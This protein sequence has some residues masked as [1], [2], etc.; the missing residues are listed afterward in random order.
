MGTSLSMDSA[1]A[2]IETR[3]RR[4]I[5]LAVVVWLLAVEPVRLAL[6]L[7]GALPRLSTFGAVDW[8]VV[9]ARV[10]LVAA[11]VAVGRRLRAPSREAWR[12]VAIW[13]AASIA[14]SMLSQ[15]WPA[16][17]TGRAPSEARIATALAVVR[18][19][20]LALAAVTLARRGRG[21]RAST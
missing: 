21:P 3:A 12:A 14:V 6:A 9:A 11:A 7:D 17:P 4:A 1:A 8:L 2:P 20:L 10:A 16:L 5:R 18:D 15:A 19:V 13:A